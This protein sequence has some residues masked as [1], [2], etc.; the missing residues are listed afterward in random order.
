LGLKHNRPR[1]L[2]PT[3]DGEISIRIHKSFAKLNLELEE[4]STTK[5]ESIEKEITQKIG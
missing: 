4:K 3:K 5:C 2:L 1:A